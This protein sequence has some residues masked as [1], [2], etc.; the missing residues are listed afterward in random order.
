MS[1]NARCDF[2]GAHK[3]EIPP[4]THR[5]GGG[6]GYFAACDYHTAYLR[7]NFRTIRPIV[8]LHYV[9]AIDGS[10]KALLVGPF[11]SHA[12]ALARVDDASKLAES[13]YSDAAFAAFGTLSIR[14]R[15]NAPRGK[16]NE[17]FGLAPAVIDWDDE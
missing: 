3:G 4:A 15:N 6:G 16:L 9:S 8:R 7:Q 11:T 14:P 5:L 12:A 17:L 10:R 13:T 2:S 1:E